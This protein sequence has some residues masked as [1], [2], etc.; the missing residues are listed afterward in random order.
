MAGWCRTMLTHTSFLL[1]FGFS[2][3]W[4][5]LS[6]LCTSEVPYVRNKQINVGWLI[7]GKHA[8]W[9]PCALRPFFCVHISFSCVNSKCTFF[10]PMWLKHTKY[11][12]IWCL[13]WLSNTSSPS[14]C[15]TE[16]CTVS[17]HWCRQVVSIYA[18]RPL[19]YSS[20]RP[21]NTPLLRTIMIWIL[22]LKSSVLLANLAADMCPIPGFC[23]VM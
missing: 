2:F 19:N 1:C 17:G 15:I 11:Y 7:H 6:Q 14:L 5:F 3:I 23:H 18:G 4:V 10:P 13:P 16:S 21:K 9:L 8:V 12:W 20:L 22:H